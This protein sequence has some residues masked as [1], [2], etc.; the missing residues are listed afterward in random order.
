[1]NNTFQCNRNYLNKILKKPLNIFI[2]VLFLFLFLFSL[3]SSKKQE[4]EFFVEFNHAYGLKQGTVVNLRGIKIGYVHS[5]SVH[6]NKVVVLLRISS[7]KIL[8][9]KKSIIEVNQIGLFNDVVIDITPINIYYQLSQLSDP[10]SP[11]CFHSNY[12]CASSYTRGYKGLNYDDLIRATTRI[13]QRFDD[14]RFFSLFYLLLQNS[15]DISSEIVFF[16]HNVFYFC[17]H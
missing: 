7:L 4:Y 6:L 5:I 1:M 13:S 12:L 16:I 15:I 11:D 2:F 8:I 9:P 3:L 10:S 14:P 17:V